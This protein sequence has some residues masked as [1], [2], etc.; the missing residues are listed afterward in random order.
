MTSPIEWER[1]EDKCLYMDTSRKDHKDTMSDEGLEKR[2]VT[3]MNRK[4][5]KKSI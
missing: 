2:K 5:S 4:K 1:M 3:A